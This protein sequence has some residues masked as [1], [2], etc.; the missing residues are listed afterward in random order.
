MPKLG[1]NFTEENPFRSKHRINFLTVKLDAI[2]GI[3]EKEKV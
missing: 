1:L 3:D 2:C